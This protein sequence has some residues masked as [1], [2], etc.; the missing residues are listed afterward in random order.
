MSQTPQQLIAYYQN[1]LI[2]QYNG[3][4]KA[5]AHIAAL[6]TPAIIPQTTIQ[7]IAFSVAPSSGSFKLNYGAQSTS[8]IAWNASAATI[9]SA[10]QALTGLG[11]VTVSGSIAS[12]LLV[13]TFTGV[14][15]VA[16]LL[17]A[18][19]NTTGAAITITEVDET[20]PLAVR[21]AFNLNGSN[22]AQGVQL[23][24][25]GEYLGVTR[26]GYVVGV[27]NIVLSDSDF[28]SLIRFAIIR[29]TS[30]SSLYTIQA[31]I[32]Q[33]FPGEI[34]VFDYS[35][36]QMSYLVSTAIGSEN[37]V[38]LLIA[39]NLLPKPMA[40]S[41]GAVIYAPIITTFFGFRTYTINTVNNTPFNSYST[42][43]LFRPW[44]TYADS[45]TANNTTFSLELE[46]GGLLLQEDS[47][48]IL[49]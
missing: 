34:L 7:N 43:S 9:Q 31:L 42:Y 35:N 33:F 44:L 28:L 19:P 21:D 5:S 45:L 30:G 11:S 32:A 22:P 39:E 36:M 4:T 18:S 8:S 47:G 27:G 40:V 12:Q 46:T 29:N 26:S 37:L 15:A 23:D 16:S 38:L 3:L 20:I 10:L 41:L 48:S 17:T 25:L 2:N 6:V 13:V 24:I 14:V 1:L 49:L